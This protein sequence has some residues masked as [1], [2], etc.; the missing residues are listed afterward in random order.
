[1]LM[2]T[3]IPA[4]AAQFTRLAVLVCSES[5]LLSFVAWSQHPESFGFISSPCELENFIKKNYSMLVG[6]QPL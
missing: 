2:Q 6:I 1:M 5:D 4:N 3:P